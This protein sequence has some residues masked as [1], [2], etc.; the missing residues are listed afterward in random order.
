MGFLDS[1]FSNKAVADK[2]LGFLKNTMKEQ[3]VKYVVLS[4]KPDDEFDIQMLKEDQKPVIYSQETVD[5]MTKV[6]EEQS[7]HIGRLIEMCREQESEISQTN[8][9]LS[10]YR[11][12][13]ST[14]EILR[15]EKACF[16]QVNKTTETQPN[17]NNNQ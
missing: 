6:F 11:M 17:D 13:T 10:E 9:A 14:D 16:S 2:A 1:I 8:A 3:N 7:T 15:I 12:I 5:E 4:L